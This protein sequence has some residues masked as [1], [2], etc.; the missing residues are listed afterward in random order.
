MNLLNNLK[1]I[2]F[3]LLA[4]TIPVSVAFTNVFLVVFLIV[5]LLEGD[6]IRKIHVFKSNK[7]LWSVL[8]LTI[9]YF[10]GLMYGHNHNDANY[11]L[12]RVSLLL[13][14]I[15]FTT[16]EIRQ[17]SYHYALTLFLFTNLI[18]ATVSILINNEIIEPIS[19]YIPIISSENSISAFLKYNYH[20]ILLSFSSLLSFMLFHLSKNKY[21]FLYLLAIP[22]FCLSI[23]S[24][25]GRAGQLT[26]NVFM[27]FYAIYFLRSKIKYSISI[28]FFLILVNYF[29]YNNSTVF[30]YRVDQLNHV[31][32]NNGEKKNPKA[33]EKDIRYLFLNESLSLIKERPFFGHGSGSFSSILISNTNSS[34]DFEKHKTPHNNFLYV[35][36]ELGI[37]GFLI[38]LSIFYYQIKSI[39]KNSNMKIHSI[40]LPLFYLF[41]MLFDSY[42]FIFTITVMYMFMYKIFSEIDL[43]FKKRLLQ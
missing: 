25:A 6:F 22:I 7:W 35:F 18:S 15:V 20:N 16:A 27:F 41:L 33:K 13:M 38:F 37:F 8:V 28:F 5:W 17:K 29:S 10:L 12:Q 34:Y 31:V 39:L 26:I 9:M 40:I 43:K 24:E 19:S 14:F 36:F 42:L 3:V 2:V 11:V 30:K 23:F 32:Q 1:N 21:S 4:F